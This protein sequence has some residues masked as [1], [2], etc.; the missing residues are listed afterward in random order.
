MEQNRTQKHTVVL[1]PLPLQGHITPMLQL[2]NIL[3]SKGFSIVVAHSEFRPP[4]PLNHPEFILHPLS[5]NLSGYQASSNN[6]VELI[7]AINSNCRAPLEDYMVQLMEDQ[8]LQGYQVACIIY[9]SHLCFVD[10]VATHLKIPGIIL[11]PD[12]AVY[13]LAFRYFCQLE[14]EN[15]ISFPGSRLQEPVPGLHPLRFKDLP[16]PI[17]NEIPEWIMDFFASSVNI[18]SSVAIILNTT[19]CLEH[20]TLSQLQQCYKVPCFPIAPLHK[21]GAAATSTSFLE[22]DQSC[23]AWLEKQPPNSVLYISFGSIACVN[24]QELTETA[25]GLGNSGIPFIWVLRSDSIDGSQLEDHFPEAVKALLGERG[26]IVKW[27][28]QKKV[29][30]HS[31][32][33]GFW[34]HC[35]WNS[36]IESICEGVPMICRPHFAD[37]LSNARYLTSEWKVGLEIENVLDRGSIEISIRRLMV[38]AEGKEMR[39]IMSVMKDKLEAGLQKGGSSYESLNDLT[40]FISQLPSMVQ[41]VKVDDP[42]TSVSKNLIQFEGLKNLV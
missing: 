20:S 26:L 15:R 9:D 32:V 2:G 21:L 41:E 40:E 3:Y 16:Y 24:E 31:A 29:L 33:G 30:A 28:P 27:A 34:S 36:T 6:L 11:R 19:D 10:S 37:Q 13:M 35:G 14:A 7:L 1:V 25:W 39:Q 8:K 12:M 22:E 5:D 18:R 17:T 23:I 4:N 38:D 42:A